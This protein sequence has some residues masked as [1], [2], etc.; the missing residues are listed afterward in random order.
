MHEPAFYLIHRP[1]YIYIYIYSSGVSFPTL[2]F[3]FDVHCA[4]ATFTNKIVCYTYMYYNL[5]F[6]VRLQIINYYVYNT[7]LII[8]NLT[9]VN[10][11]ILQI[12]EK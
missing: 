10:K 3:L 11:V 9:P 5:C 7:S 6:S 1:V 2:P 8:I 12:Y 4:I